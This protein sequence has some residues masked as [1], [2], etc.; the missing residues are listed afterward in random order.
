MM[1]TPGSPRKAREA[2]SETW[3]WEGDCDYLERGSPLAPLRSAISVANT[4]LIL[5]GH[6]DSARNLRDDWVYVLAHVADLEATLAGL[7]ES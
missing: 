5:L 2:K 3:A 1:K 4:L 7:I 6:Y